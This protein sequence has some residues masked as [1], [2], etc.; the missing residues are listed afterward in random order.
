MGHAGRVS[1]AAIVWFVLALALGGAELATLTLALGMGAVACAAGGAAAL[2]GAPVAGQGAAF[3]AVLAVL[4]V[5]VRPV[6]RRHLSTALSNAPT[7]TAA[8]IGTQARVIIPVGAE[9]GQVR[10]GGELWSAR[11]AFPVG[12]APLPTGSTV[13]ITAVDGASVVVSPLEIL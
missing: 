7:G 10:L 9:G 4:L 5:G 11:L 1:T 13:V 6:V 3:A 2:L 12:A 8:L